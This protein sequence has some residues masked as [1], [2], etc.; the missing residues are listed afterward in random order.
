MHGGTR[1][2]FGMEAAFQALR[3]QMAVSRMNPCHIPISGH[4]ERKQEETDN[5]IISAPLTLLI[6]LWETSK[7]AST[8]EVP[9]VLFPP[10]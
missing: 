2:F 4:R 7:I 6:Y 10:I 8:C 1:H 9:K 3:F 5:F